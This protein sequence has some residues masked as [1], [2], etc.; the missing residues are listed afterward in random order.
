MKPTATRATPR[1]SPTRP[2]CRHRAP[3][4]GIGPDPSAVDAAPS[5]RR[6]RRPPGPRRT[7]SWRWR[8]AGPQDGFGRHRHHHPDAHPQRDPGVGPAPLAPA[9]GDQGHPEHRHREQHP[10]HPVHPGPVVADQ[11]LGHGPVA[12]E[13]GAQRQGEAAGGHHRHQPGQG[14]QHVGQQH[15]VVGDRAVVDGGRHPHGGGQVGDGHA[16]ILAPPGGPAS[17]RPCAASGPGI[18]RLDEGRC[19]FAWRRPVPGF[20][21]GYRG[22]RQVWR[23]DRRSLRS[24]APF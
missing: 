20:D 17:D 10:A 14:A 18:A 2:A 11:R 15:E 1:P 6:R 4:S 8:S 12:A 24:A 3:S 21:D 5:G 13:G 19:S 7:T 9:H 16:V 22:G 23:N